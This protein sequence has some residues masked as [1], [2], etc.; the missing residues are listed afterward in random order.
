MHDEV[1]EAALG[2]GRFE[3]DMTGLRAACWSVFELYQAALA[4]EIGEASVV[5]RKV[6]WSAFLASRSADEEAVPAALE[7]QEKLFRETFD[8]VEVRTEFATR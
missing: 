8:S 3:P 5:A 1:F 7:Y 2:M 4:A 6:A